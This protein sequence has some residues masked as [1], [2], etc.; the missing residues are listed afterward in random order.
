M[1]N[2]RIRVPKTAKAGDAV[3]IRAIIQHPMENGFRLDSQG[4]AI[5]VEII[6]DFTCTYDG[7]EVFSVKLEP[8]LSAN[9]YFSFYLKAT[10]SGPVDFRWVDQDGTITTATEQLDV[11]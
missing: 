10:K 6:T 9:P 11:T 5:P 7:G 3:E 4:T 1:P 2:T 8:G